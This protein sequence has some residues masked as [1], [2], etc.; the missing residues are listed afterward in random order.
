MLARD[1]VAAAFGVKY[2]TSG[3]IVQGDVLPGAYTLVIYAR[4]MET[5]QFDNVRVV[6]VVVQ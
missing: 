1:D 2:L 4:S 3:F 5:G 6:P